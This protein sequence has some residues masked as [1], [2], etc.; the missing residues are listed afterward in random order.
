[1]VLRIREGTDVRVYTGE[2]E[3]TGVCTCSYGHGQGRRDSWV[4]S[5]GPWSKKVLLPI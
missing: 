1:M 3:R 2:S 4:S 5:P